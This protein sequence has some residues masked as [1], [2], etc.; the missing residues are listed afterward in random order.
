MVSQPGNHYDCIQLRL[1][2]QM[3]CVYV[4]GNKN[5]CFMQGDEAGA[6]VQVGASQET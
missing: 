1:S 3:Q 2:V 4:Q 6:V 5:E